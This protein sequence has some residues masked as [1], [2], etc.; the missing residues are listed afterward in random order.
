VSFMDVM[1]TLKRSNSA[2][3]I[4]I[5]RGP[6]INAIL[7][8]LLVNTIINMSQITI[9]KSL[10]TKKLFRK[11]L[12]PRHKFKTLNLVARERLQKTI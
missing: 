9:M 7:Y 6:L 5:L 11:P 8:Q 1:T 12:S 3:E 2:Q 4:S 10:K